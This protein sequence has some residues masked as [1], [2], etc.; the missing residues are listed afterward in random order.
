MLCQR[1][2]GFGSRRGHARTL[3]ENSVEKSAEMAQKLRQNAF[4]T[5]QTAWVL[6]SLGC[7]CRTRWS[8]RFEI[9]M[10]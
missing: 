1:R 3:T 5:R 2:R 4:V 8:F 7:F 10:A 9:C 6:V